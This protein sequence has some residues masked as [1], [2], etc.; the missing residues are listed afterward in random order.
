MGLSFAI[1]IDVA[2]QVVEQLRSSGTVTRG[3]IG[4]TI[5]ELTREL[6][7]SFGLS[8]PEGALI[9]SVEKNGPADKAGIEVSDV[10]LKFDGK[11]VIGS[12]DL[13]RIVAATRPGS[14]A[15]VEL[16]RK[17]AV[18]QVTVE[19]AEMPEEGKQARAVIDGLEADVVT[20]ALAY[21]IDA[22]AEKAKLLPLDWQKRLPHNSSPYTSTIV[23][24]VRK[25]NP[26]AI[27]DWSD[28]AGPGVQM[29]IPH[30]KNTGNGRAGGS[31]TAALFLQKFVNGLPWAH[32]DIAGTAWLEEGKPYLAKGPSGLPVRTFVELALAFGK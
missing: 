26:K 32:L 10:I 5:Q 1:P 11:A 17:G 3:R 14:K 4:V 25:G 7:E 20:L 19:V 15:V 29:I 22:I 12:A 8:K 31:I 18:K 30:P 6:A 9:S 23:F 27:K 24:L 2:T 16:W 13:P 28:I 21:D